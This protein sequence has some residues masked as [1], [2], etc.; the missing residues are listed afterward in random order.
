[1]GPLLLLLKHWH[2]RQKEQKV[3]LSF[4]PTVKGDDTPSWTTLEP[5]APTDDPLAYVEVSDN[6]SSSD[7][8]VNFDSDGID[9]EP[10]ARTGVK[11]NSKVAATK[12]PPMESDIEVSQ[13]RWKGKQRQV[14]D[15]DS[16]VE[17]SQPRP[18]QKDDTIPPPPKP[19]ARNAN[20]RPKQKLVVESE[21]DEPPVV[22]KP[23]PRPTA[24][25]RKSVKVSASDNDSSGNS[26]EEKLK[27][28]ARLS[29]VAHDQLEDSSMSP[30]N[31]KPVK[32]S[33]S[34]NDS[35]S[36]SAEEKFEK[37]V[38]LSKAGHHLED[39][40]TSNAA[41]GLVRKPTVTDRL[42]PVDIAA[43]DD[44]RFGFL[45]TLAPNHQEYMALLRC[46]L[47]WKVPGF[48]S[49]TPALPV[50]GRWDYS[51]EW[52]PKEFYSKQGYQEFLA[53]LRKNPH[54]GLG[55][56]LGDRRGVEGMMLAIGMVLRDFATVCFSSN[57]PESFALSGAPPYVHAFNYQLKH[58]DEVLLS[59]S[60]RHATFSSSRS[61]YVHSD[62]SDSIPSI[63]VKSSTTSSKMSSGSSKRNAPSSVDSDIEVVAS[64]KPTAASS[65][66][67]SGSSK[68]HA[69]P[70]VDSDPEVVPSTKPSVASSRSTRSNEA[71][72]TASVSS[73]TMS[74]GSSGRNAPPSV[75][76]DVVLLPNAAA[77]GR[78]SVLLPIC[79][80]LKVD[81][82][83]LGTHWRFLCTTWVGVEKALPVD[84]SYESLV[85]FPGLPPKA[86]EWVAAVLSGS[87]TKEPTLIESADTVASLQEWLTECID[88][89]KEASDPS[90][91]PF[92][93]RGGHGFLI[94][95]WAAKIWGLHMVNRNVSKNS[96]E[97]G[98][99][100][101]V[102][103][104]LSTLLKKRSQE[105][106]EGRAA[107]TGKYEAALKAIQPKT[108]GQKKSG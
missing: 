27:K 59:S 106:R 91:L 45:E 44:E 97:W 30:P 42:A 38:H 41:P 98:P 48:V 78:Y 80:F 46:L 14:V 10:P 5:S 73:S 52:C 76:T 56:N 61:V 88:A 3:P 11:T 13:P 60:S 108:R 72:S 58:Q 26:A 24:K 23:Q 57:D 49:I 85:V 25:K 40:S 47:S 70:A 4:F 105:K 9:Q 37:K 102:V 107:K 71:K 103:N 6:A 84:E 86:Q 99:F 15:S 17:V 77:L 96:N 69:P 87:D 22:K 18:K 50:W 64:T 12:P 7:D 20:I 55:E 83:R 29:K 74:S 66:T 104:A 16:D 1:M 94:T 21:A 39:S 89:S 65:K 43:T 93:Q 19:S 36:D 54:Q 90:M 28:K 81:V 63:S 51:D 79:G 75:N 8:P 67:S 53:Y 101:D 62:D 35:S 31:T 68:H 95:M 33:A 2:A 32:A 34:N 92:M 100:R 82:G